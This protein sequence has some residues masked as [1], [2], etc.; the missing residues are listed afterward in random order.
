[1][2]HTDLAAWMFQKATA[3]H[4]WRAMAFSWYC[5]CRA[6]WRTPA[7]RNN[8]TSLKNWGQPG[9]PRRSIEGIVVLG[10]KDT[11][12]HNKATVSQ[13][14]ALLYPIQGS[15]ES[16]QFSGAGVDDTPTPTRAHTVSCTWSLYLCG[17]RYL[18]MCLHWW[19]SIQRYGQITRCLDYIYIYNVY[20][21]SSVFIHIIYGRM[22]DLAFSWHKLFL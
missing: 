19:L 12:T 11:L 6:S 16:C 22:R 7:W 15:R 20:V 14:G 4:S 10:T 18:S 8:P 21:H 5:V 2:A 1:M 17:T 9:L 3:G 13:H